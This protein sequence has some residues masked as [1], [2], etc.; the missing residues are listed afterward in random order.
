MI[1][2]NV[3]HGESE[4]TGEKR[5][6]TPPSCTNLGSISELT[7]GGGGRNANDGGGMGISS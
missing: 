5:T 2:E 3:E 6:F 1:N 4:R 7:E